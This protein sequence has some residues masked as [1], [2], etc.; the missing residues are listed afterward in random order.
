MSFGIYFSQR[1]QMPHTKAFIQLKQIKQPYLIFK[2]LIHFN[3][4]KQ[5]CVGLFINH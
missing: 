2:C 1:R 3:N 4:A 5:I